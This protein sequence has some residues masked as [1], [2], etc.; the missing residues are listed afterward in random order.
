M[1]FTQSFAKY[2]D[3]KSR[4]QGAQYA[5]SDKVELD[6]I[7]LSNM[8]LDAKVKDAKKYAV[9]VE[10]TPNYEAIKSSCTCAEYKSGMFCKH[11]WATFVTIEAK[12]KVAKQFVTS[13]DMTLSHVDDPTPNAAIRIEPENNPSPRPVEQEVED[14]SLGWKKLERLFASNGQPIPKTAPQIERLIWYGI[15]PPFP[16]FCHFININL[17]QQEISSRGSYGKVK[18][19]NDIDS[20][21][22]E[23]LAKDDFEIFQR[24]GAKSARFRNA[25]NSSKIDSDINTHNKFL[26]KSGLRLGDAEL[27]AL[28]QLMAQ[29]RR[30][31]YLGYNFENTPSPL[32]F[33]SKEI[34]QIHLNLTEGTNAKQQLKPSFH[35]KDKTIQPEDALAFHSSGLVFEHEQI[36]MRDTSSQVLESILE[37]ILQEGPI[38][39]FKREVDAFFAKALE[40]EFD[41]LKSSASQFGWHESISTPKP[42]L[43][44]GIP[45]LDDLYQ[46]Q[47]VTATVLFSYGEKSVAFADTKKVIADQKTRRFLRRQIRIEQDAFTSLTSLLAARNI[48]HNLFDGGVLR[49]PT[50]Q[51]ITAVEE[52]IELGWQVEGETFSINKLGQMK[53]F[54][55]YGIKWLSVSINSEI[56]EDLIAKPAILQA[57]RKGTPYVKL[58]NG[59]VGILPEEWL[60][61]FS[62]LA[63]SGRVDDDGIKLDPK[64]AFFVAS[65]MGD[66]NN[67]DS[68]EGWRDID[69]KLKNLGSPKAMDPVHGF[70]G[71]LRHYQKEGLGW[72]NHLKAMNIGACLADDMGLGKT[73]QVLAFMHQHYSEERKTHRP[74]L[75]VAP[76]S[77]MFNWFA[78]AKKFAPSLRVAEYASSVRFNINEVKNN[79][80]LFLTTYGIMRQDIELLKEIDFDLVILD[81]AQYI[82]NNASLTS[83]F[84]K[85]LKAQ[86]RIALTGTPIEN[87]TGE[88]GSILEFLDQD[89]F[90]SVIKTLSPTKTIHSPE[91][92]KL[93]SETLRPF[94]LRR[95]KQQVLQDLP[96]K[97][98]QTIFCTLGSDQQKTYDELHDFYSQ[99][100]TRLLEE[101]P[102]K[103]KFK[104]LEALTRL[105]QAACD[106]RLIEGS[107]AA[108]SKIDLLME[109]VQQVIES[110]GKALIFSQF[111]KFLDLVRNRLDQGG[112]PYEY[113]DGATQDRQDRVANFQT[114]PTIKMFLISLKAGGTGLNL[115]AADYC[116]ILDPWWNPAA[117]SQAIDRAHRFGQT[118]KVMAYRLIAKDTVEERIL[119]LQ[120]KKREVVDSILTENNSALGNLSL[121]DLKGLFL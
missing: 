95:T 105:R 96:E 37:H 73:V 91:K 82:K 119:E 4:A 7:D 56:P 90:G 19:V 66:A 76:K 10:T 117:E 60:N 46:L 22:L 80:D 20:E 69:E 87:H 114:N 8:R 36:S 94:I 104:L 58:G 111:T 121:D 83:R 50:N 110:G 54:I 59:R 2:F 23:S 9:Q 32:Q 92:L 48:K 88:L 102:A 81:E 24:L 1:P 70:K 61:K 100:V 52:L 103:A 49:L 16:R 101:S 14:S 65:V 118:K 21:F 72:L 78:E 5:S 89:T 25:F 31:F 98:E 42:M 64:Q 55:S 30:L 17:M 15:S 106:P 33:D 12:T 93:L 113:L 74:S 71:N 86:H 53:P 120:S 116:F 67:Y 3:E 26:N 38:E 79:Y 62:I 75:I 99:E 41:A 108:G 47:D 84:A 40:T 85:Q 77:L 6:S 35:S 28:L 11:I 51:L 112:I 27:P 44:L 18:P 39:L 63:Q 68:D 13:D 34:W 45:S 107:A 115:T 57:L 43:R 29:T 97:L 109:Q